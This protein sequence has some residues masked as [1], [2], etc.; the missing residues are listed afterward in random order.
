MSHKPALHLRDRAKK[1]VKDEPMRKAV[2][3]AAA[4][5]H[6]SRCRNEMRLRFTLEKAGREVIR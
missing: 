5:V 6:R 2:Q 1:A 3:N 4:K